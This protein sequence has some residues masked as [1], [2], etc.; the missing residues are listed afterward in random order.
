[1]TSP[2]ALPH[3]PWLR[4][5]EAAA[6]RQSFSAAAQE[7]HL[8]VAAISLQI[9][10]LEQRLGFALFE[11]RARGVALTEMGH[12]YL[13]AVRRAFDELAVATAG[14]FGGLGRRAVT[15]RANTA[16]AVLW[17][18]PRLPA[19]RAAHPD[20]HVRLLSSTWADGLEAGSVDLDIRFGDGRWDGH[21]IEPLLHGPSVPVCSPDWPRRAT[22]REPLA[23]LAR[24]HLIHIMGCED[25]WTRWFGAEDGDHSAVEAGVQVDTSLAALE[26]AAAGGGF[27]IVLRSFAEPY[28]RDGRLVAPFA[29]VLPIGDGLHLLSPRS[30][31]APRPE[32]LQ[33][34]QWLLAQCR[35]TTA[36]ASMARNLP[37]RRG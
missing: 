30:P 11:R 7:L 22:R 16:F 4:A 26:L 10:S 6:R 8:S 1:M 31:A 28:L 12:A 23:R 9:R 5:F 19:F 27:A 36:S 35:A 29:R 25:L 32:V 34:R 15:V 17:L 21:V 2:H 13:P 37:A 18:A 33:F 24:R 20:I 3:L 14:L